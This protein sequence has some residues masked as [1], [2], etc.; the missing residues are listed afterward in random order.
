MLLERADRKDQP[1]VPNEV[2]LNSRPGKLV[3]GECRTS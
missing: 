2:L 3:E 1:L